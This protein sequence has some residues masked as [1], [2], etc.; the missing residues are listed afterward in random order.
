MVFFAYMYKCYKYNIALLP[1]EA[2]I[3]LSKK[4]ALKRG[5]SGITEKND[6]HPRKYGISVEVPY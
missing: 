1:K 6:I 2:K 3:I 5:I 4:N